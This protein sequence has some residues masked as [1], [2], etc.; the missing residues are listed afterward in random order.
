MFAEKIGHATKNQYLCNKIN[1]RMR[2]Y[3]LLFFLLS[4]MIGAEAQTRTISGSLYDGELKEAVPYAAVQLLKD[5]ADSTYV[6]S[7]DRREAVSLH[8]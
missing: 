5:N 4:V 8:S 1:K 2:K 7:D 3:L 6:T